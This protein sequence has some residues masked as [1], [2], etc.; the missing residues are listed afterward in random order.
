[1]TQKIKE[2]I[3]ALANIKDAVEMKYL[4]DCALVDMTALRAKVAAELVDLTALRAT[5]AA[6]V[7]DLAAMRTPI[8]ATVVDVTAMRTAARTKMLSPAGLAIGPSAKLT[9]QAAKPFMA[10]AGG[11]LVYKPAATEMSVLPASTTTQGKFG[12]WAFYID[13]AGT[14]TTSARTAE[15]DTAV[16]AFALMP[17][18]PASKA[19]IGAIIVTDA[20]SVFVAG[21]DALDAQG[22][23][24]IYID[25]VGLQTDAVALTA[26]AP[27]ALTSAAPSALTTTTIA[28]LTLAA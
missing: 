8:A 12:L 28:A 24:T 25:T 27:A 14:I 11:T 16:A 15:A 20:D 19:Q 9:A 18:V 10:L 5:V 26:S 1:M 17:A 21:T 6:A 7:V 22:V 2:R 13:S 23:T 4:W 3:S